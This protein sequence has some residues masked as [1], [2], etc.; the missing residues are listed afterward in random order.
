MAMWRIQTGAS[1]SYAGISPGFGASQRVTDGMGGAWT[2]CDG[3]GHGCARGKGPVCAW[4]PAL[5]VGKGQCFGN[6]ARSQWS[7]L[8]AHV[9]AAKA[10]HCCPELPI[11]QNVGTRR[12]ALDSQRGLSVNAVVLRVDRHQSA[13]AGARCLG[14][15]S[16]PSANWW[17][18][19]ALGKWSRRQG[20]KQ[21]CLWPGL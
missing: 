11:G 17:A 1:C 21:H 19:A 12:H 9:G 2:G 5:F 8:G 4:Q 18:R 16:P 20:R 14:T 10:V 6:K 7:S 3:W 13:A 15:L